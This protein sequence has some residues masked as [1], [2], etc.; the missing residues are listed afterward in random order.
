[1]SNWIDCKDS[2]PDKD[3]L[4]LVFR[5]DAAKYQDP[6]VRTAKFTGEHYACYV[7][8]SHWMRIPKCPEPTK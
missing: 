6:L 2:K 3:E 7:Q 5:P 4:V 1:M 8:P